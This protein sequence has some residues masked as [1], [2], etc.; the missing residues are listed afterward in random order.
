[1]AKQSSSGLRPEGLSSRI[2]K[3]TAVFGSVQGVAMLCTLVLNKVKAKL[4]GSAGFGLAEGFNRSTELVRSSTGLGVGSTAVQQVSLYSDSPEELDSMVLVTR[5]WALLT[6]M[7]GMLLC[8]VLSGAL[9]R[10][11]FKDDSSFAPQFM[12]MSLSVAASAVSGGEMAILKGTGRLRHVALSQLF[13]A[14][15]SL[16]LSVP[17]YWLLGLD[18]VAPALALSALGTLA[19]TCF[20]SFKA[21]PYRVR[22]FSGAVLKR[23]FGMIGF[24]IFFTIA[25]FLSSWAWSFLARYLYVHGGEE[26][27]GTYSAGWMLVTYMTTLLLT[28]NDSEYYPRLSAAS[29]NQVE[30]NRIAA[31]QSQTMLMLASPLVMAFIVGMPLVVLVVLDSVKFSESVALAQLAVIGLLFK[32]AYQPVA[33]M[34]LAKLDGKIYVAQELA[35]YLML[36]GCV[37]P[38][39]SLGGLTGV[40]LGLAVWELLYLVMILIVAGL[41]FRFVPPVPLVRRFVIQLALTCVCAAG[42]VVVRG[43]IGYAVGGAAMVASALYSFVFL[44]RN[45]GLTFFRKSN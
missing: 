2:L 28:V 1:M 39:Y 29:G 41:R 5:S 36:I 16:L 18:G 42:C 21:F 4:L 38:G 44:R 31:C 40:G 26:L 23:G 9:S 8:L 12:M 13:A 25:A 32:S 34:A 43:A 6:A 35:C 27:T 45:G 33:Y 11:A 10:W 14:V 24:G 37:L 17:L 19:V 20:F 22:P 3:Y 15:F 30:M 7:V